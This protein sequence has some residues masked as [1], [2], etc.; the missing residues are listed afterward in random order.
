MEILKNIL[1]IMH[2][3]YPFCGILAGFLL[4]LRYKSGNRSRLFLAVCFGLAGIMTLVMLCNNYGD[5]RSSMDVLEIEKLN[6][7][8]LVFLMFFFYPIEVINPYWLTLKKSLLLFSPWILLNVWLIIFKPE[9]RALAS[10]HDIVAFSGEFNVWSRLFILIMM[11]PGSCILLYIPYN[12]SK[13]R[14]SISW[15]RWYTIGTQGI[16]L[17]YI[18]YL[19]T[20]S[21][22]PFI[23]HKVYCMLFLLVVTYQ[24]LYLRMPVAQATIR[25][26]KVDES[27]LF[28][29][30]ESCLNINQQELW[31]KLEKIMEDKKPWINPDLTSAD[32]A[33]LLNTNRTTLSRLI[34]ANGYDG[35]T[36]FINRRRIKEFMEIIRH[37]EISGIQETFYDVGFRSKSTALRYFRQETG[38]TPTKYL[39]QLLVDEKHQHSS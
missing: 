10:F 32:L 38:T 21:I 11:I 39:Q 19:L 22:Y 35:Y 20:G 29:E 37:K 12:W 3:F 5:L 17:L 16:T 2:H 26:A 28:V 34:N 30:K 27:L 6:G 24:E 8:L 4:F 1:A 33:S 7:G 13:S 36:S 18:F 23:A 9:F 15:I 14:A 25:S 31:V